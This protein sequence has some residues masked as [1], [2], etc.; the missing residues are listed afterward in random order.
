VETPALSPFRLVIA[1]LLLSL[2]LLQ[3]QLSLFN[4]LL[5]PLPEC[6]R[7]GG[8]IVDEFAIRCGKKSAYGRPDRWPVYCYTPVV[9]S[10]VPGRL[11]V[12]GFRGG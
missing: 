4:F 8:A 5:L 3:L 9:K 2:L 7:V 11:S 6:R 12:G 10:G 1:M